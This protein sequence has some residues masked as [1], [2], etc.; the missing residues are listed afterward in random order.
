VIRIETSPAARFGFSG[1][2]SPL[3][4]NGTVPFSNLTAESWRLK[5][6]CYP[7]DFTASFPDLA[8]TISDTSKAA[9]ITMALSAT[10]NAGQ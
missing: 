7:L 6:D 10:L 2:I 9:P 1:S 4:V 8:K 5:A 3:A